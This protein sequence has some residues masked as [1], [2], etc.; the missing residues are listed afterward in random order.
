MEFDNLGFRF[1]YDVKV[2]DHAPARVPDYCFEFSRRSIE[3]GRLSFETQ[4]RGA[5]ARLLEVVTSE[6]KVWVGRFEAGP[7][8][9]SGCFATPS[10]NTLCIVVQGQGY[11]I[12]VLQPASYEVVAVTPIKQ[13]LRVPDQDTMLFIDFVRV[14]A[15]GP[16]GFLW[17]TDDLSWD[18]VQITDVN[19]RSIRGLG[20][21]SPGDCYV[22]FSIDTSTGT[23][24]GGSSPRHY[25]K[26]T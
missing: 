1:N 6:G 3:G 5:N 16:E 15:Y 8:G 9:L 13:V 19:A 10:P 26:T 14:S 12:P 2:L 25:S 17:R 24:T 22:D 4:P 18:G 20:W 23:A 11:W 7:E 21:D